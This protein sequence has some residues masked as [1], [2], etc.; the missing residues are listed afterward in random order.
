MYTEEI[1]T[2]LAEPHLDNSEK[3]TTLFRETLTSTIN[4][5]TTLIGY[6]QISTYNHL[7]VIVELKYSVKAS[8]LLSKMYKKITNDYNLDMIRIDSE[9]LAH[10]ADSQYEYTFKLIRTE[11]LKK[12]INTANVIISKIDESILNNKEYLDV[13]L[14]EGYKTQLL[15]EISNMSGSLEVTEIKKRNQNY[16]FK[17]KSWY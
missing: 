13:E 7:N 11:A 8:D 1:N 9:N 5:S 3:R 12:F 17:A 4:P 2:F 10:L 16:N 6:V 14:L 15:I